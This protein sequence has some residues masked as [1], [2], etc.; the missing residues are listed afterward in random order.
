MSNCEL[1]RRCAVLAVLVLA[2]AGCGQSEQPSSATATHTPAA[3]S[4]AE[5]QAPVRVARADAPLPPSKPADNESDQAADENIETPAE[6]AAP[7]V[8][9]ADAPLEKLPSAKASIPYGERAEAELTMPHVSL[10]EGHAK[11][12]P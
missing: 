5:I 1:T 3:P 11:A 6:P 9:H 12:C 8:A 4:P 7:A 2:L 10:T